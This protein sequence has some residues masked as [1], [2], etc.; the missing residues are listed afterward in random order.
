MNAIVA[1]AIIPYLLILAVLALGAKVFDER[2]C[3]Q[4]QDNDDQ[5][6]TKSHAHVIGDVIPPSSW[7]ISLSLL[8]DKLRFPEWLEGQVALWFRG[9]DANGYRCG[10]HDVEN[11]DGY[12]LSG[13]AVSSVDPRGPCLT[14]RNIFNAHGSTATMR[15]NPAAVSQFQ[16]RTTPTATAAPEK[17]YSARRYRTK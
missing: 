10:F 15:S 13:N 7:L 8:G 2:C 3:C 14:H 5:Q 1:S 6:P 16:F 9:Q 17:R 4:D 11:L 12:V